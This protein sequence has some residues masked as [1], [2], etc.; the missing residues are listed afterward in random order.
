MIVF[1]LAVKHLEIS[2]YFK[3]CYINTIHHYYYY[4]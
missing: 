1:T 3:V 2:L 4:Y